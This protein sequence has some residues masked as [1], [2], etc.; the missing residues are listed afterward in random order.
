MN[1][2]STDLPNSYLIPRLTIGGNSMGL[3]LRP[4][5]ATFYIDSHKTGL[6]DILTI[7]VNDIHFIFSKDISNNSLLEFPFEHQYNSNSVTWIYD[8]PSLD[9]KK[10]IASGLIKR[11]VK[12]FI[13]FCLHLMLSNFYQLKYLLRQP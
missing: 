3:I 10:M 8:S 4:T 12:A 9:K 1:I 6:N 7:L 5:M 2:Y 13:P 11:S